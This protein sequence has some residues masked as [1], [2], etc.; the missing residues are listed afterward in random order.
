MFAQKKCTPCLPGTPP[1]KV[2]KARELLAQ[3]PGW[4]IVMDG[5]AIKRRVACANFMKALALA[6]K[7][8]P[9]AEAEGHHPDLMLGWGYL[10][11]VLWTHSIAGLHENDF[12]MAAKFDEVLNNGL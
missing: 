10:E 4:E 11:M 7:L 5:R 9:I 6:G 1:M 2:E 3:L 12:I 8:A